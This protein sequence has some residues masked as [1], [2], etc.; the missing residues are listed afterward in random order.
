M[1]DLHDKA[2][3]AAKLLSA[4]QTHLGPNRRGCFEHDRQTWDAIDDAV[5]AVTDLLAENE[6]LKSELSAQVQCTVSELTKRQGAEARLKA[7][8]EAEPVAVV[9]RE[10]V[11]RVFWLSI[12]PDGTQLIPRPSMEGNTN[13]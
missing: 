10:A 3:A 1:T 12:I 8:C 6:R 9:D 5:A 13:G 4:L 11:G 7:L 2:R